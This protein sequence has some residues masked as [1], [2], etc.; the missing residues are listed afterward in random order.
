[1]P[2]AITPLQFWLGVII[3]ISPQIYN[4][5]KAHYEHKAQAPL[6]AAQAKAQEEK[7]DTEAQDALFKEYGR[8]I[9][10]LRRVE[11]E[12]KELRPLALKNAILER[13]IAECRKDKEDWKRYANKLSVQIQEL[14]HVPLP[15][16]RLPS[17]EE[18]QEKIV[19]IKRPDELQT[20]TPITEEKK[21]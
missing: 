13:D 9:E 19:T 5:I 8:Q 11:D 14:G 12:N 21:E 20:I 6:L 1:M 16:R 2:E 15:F 18:T 7:S 3:A 4:I 17:E 10:N